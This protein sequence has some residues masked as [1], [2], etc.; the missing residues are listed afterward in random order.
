MSGSV[1]WYP[2]DVDGIGAAGPPA[3]TCHSRRRSR[4][5]LP[6]DATVRS[7]PTSQPKTS[8]RQRRHRCNRLPRQQQRPPPPCLTR[9]QRRIRRR[10]DGPPSSMCS[11]PH[12]SRTSTETP[13]V[14][15]DG[16]STGVRSRSCRRKRPKPECCRRKHSGC[17]SRAFSG[18]PT[19]NRARCWSTAIRPPSGSPT[20]RVNRLRCSCSTSARSARSRR[21]TWQT[22]ESGIS[23]TLY[24]SVSSD[25]VA[26]IDLDPTLAY[27][28][29]DG[30][31][32]LDAPASAQ[33]IR[34]VFVN[35]AAADWLGGYPRSGSC[36]SA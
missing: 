4:V 18:A 24:M 28:S 7:R 31:I 1:T 12:R 32:A 34:F 25:N 2:L 23:G 8:H 5:P 14:A 16:R 29:D 10:A 15:P 35:D 19:R 36:R 26:W 21:F 3:P 6:T 9:R 30:W 27:S 33:Y 17:Q 20:A 11:R 22:G 13:V